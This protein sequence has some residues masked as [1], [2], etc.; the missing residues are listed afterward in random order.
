[1]TIGYCGWRNFE[2]W[3]ANLTWFDSFTIDD[4][5]DVHDADVEILETWMKAFVEESLFRGVADDNY[6]AMRLLN[7]FFSCIDFKQLAE[8]YMDDYLEEKN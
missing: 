2:T 4:F 3:Q 1:M 6:P 8:H 7:D 5:L